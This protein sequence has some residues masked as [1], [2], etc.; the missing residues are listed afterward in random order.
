VPVLILTGPPGAGKTTVARLLAAEAERAVHLEADWFFDVIKAGFVKPWKPESRLQNEVV[1]KIVATAAAGYAAAGYF[2]ILEGIF[3][4][5]W[6]LPPVRDSLREA[7]HDV[8]YVVLQ[9]PLSVCL[10]RAGG[11]TGRPLDDPAV[12]E[13]LWSQFADLGPFESHALDTSNLSADEVAALVAERAA[14]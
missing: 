7:G 11:R 13:Q 12:I 6:F 2:T 9:A 1:M 4:P 5:T 8:A 14:G 3:L 10:Q